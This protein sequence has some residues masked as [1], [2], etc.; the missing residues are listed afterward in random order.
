MR[1][2]GQMGPA[3]AAPKSTQGNSA[4]AIRQAAIHGKLTSGTGRGEGCRCTPLYREDGC[5]LPT[6]FRHLCD[7]PA[8]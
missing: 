8:T 2:A 7:K 5:A 1:D 6:E 3:L 4:G